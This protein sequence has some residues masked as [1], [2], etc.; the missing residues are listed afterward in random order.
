M[1]AVHGI[2][3]ELHITVPPVIVVGKTKM[4]KIFTVYVQASGFPSQSSEYVF[5]CCRIQLP[6]A[7]W[8]LPVVLLSWC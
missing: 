1:L 6:R 2:R 8:Y 7:I 5:E 4:T 3:P